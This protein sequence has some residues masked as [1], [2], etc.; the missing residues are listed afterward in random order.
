MPVLDK[1]DACV[2]PGD[3]AGRDPP[4]AARH[5]RPMGVP[6]AQGNHFGS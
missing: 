5:R 2:H 3:P 6:D 4:D 1:S